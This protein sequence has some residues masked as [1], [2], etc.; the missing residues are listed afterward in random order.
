M[1]CAFGGS[2]QIVIDRRTVL[3]AT[4]L[5]SLPLGAGCTSESRGS[6]AT[7]LPSDSPTETN[8]EASDSPIET[9]TEPSD[10]PTET[11]TK[12]E[13]PT[14]DCTEQPIMND[15]E[16]IND[17]SNATQVTVELRES[18]GEQLFR[19]RYTVPADERVSEKERIFE[20]TDESE[21]YVFAVTVNGETR[22]REVRDRFLSQPSLLGYVVELREGEFVVKD[23]HSD[24]SEIFNPNCYG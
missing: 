2:N 23:V 8:T 3:R 1:N 9:D 6:S 17:R 12:T 24:P 10:T 22:Q 18:E 19:N 7:E 15:I 16:I 20:G 13:Y 21:T 11:E 14:R 4:L 5:A